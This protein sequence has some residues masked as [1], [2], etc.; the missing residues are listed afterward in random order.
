MSAQTFTKK[1]LAKE[2]RVSIRSIENWMRTRQIDFL[3]LGK[4]IRFEVA[5]V[6]KFKKSRTVQAS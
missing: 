3:R 2:L 6:E 4:T 5:A 1:D